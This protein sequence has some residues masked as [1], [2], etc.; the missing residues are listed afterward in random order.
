MAGDVEVAEIPESNMVLTY[1]AGWHM[2]EENLT[3]NLANPREVF[4]LGSFP[5][6]PGGPN[7]A[8]IPSQALHD[9]EA[10]DVFVTLQERGSDAFPSGFEPRPDNFGPTSGST[11]NVFHDCLELEERDDVGTIHWIWFTDQDRYFHVLVAL[12]HDAAPEDVSAVWNILDQ[13]AIE[14]RS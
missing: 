11:D 13:L 7:C 3:P 2:A 5:L 6:K 8:Q 1:P 14:Q 10:T 4:S 9:L 12:G